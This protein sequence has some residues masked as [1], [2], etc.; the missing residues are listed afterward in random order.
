LAAD[1]I[2]PVQDY[3]I[4]IPQHKLPR[5]KDNST[6]SKRLPVKSNPPEQSHE[7]IT[8]DSDGRIDD[9]A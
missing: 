9:Y 5:K 1:L 4:P 3:N 2:E 6:P 8:L 7:P